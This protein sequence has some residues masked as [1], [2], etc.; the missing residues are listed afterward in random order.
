MNKVLVGTLIP[1]QRLLEETRRGYKLVF[2]K[3]VSVQE[4]STKP[5]Q[6]TFLPGLR[7]F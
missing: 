1:G 7:A 5:G 2:P 4:T 6:L 3:P